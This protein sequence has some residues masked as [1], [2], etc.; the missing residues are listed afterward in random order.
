MVDLSKDVALAAGLAEPV[1]IWGFRLSGYPVIELRSFWGFGADDDA[2]DICWT[3]YIRA[4][5]IIA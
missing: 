2:R 5:S 3:R 1:R 4:S